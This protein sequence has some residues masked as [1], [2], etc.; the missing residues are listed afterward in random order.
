[1][2]SPH[3]SGPDGKRLL[4]AL[5]IATTI[6][7]GWQYFYE[8]PQ[9]E[10]RREQAL[11]AAESKAKPDVS[12]AHAEPKAVAL[13]PITAVADAPRVKINSA[14]LHGSISLQGLRFDDLAL[15]NYRENIN[16]ESPEVRLLNHAGSADAYFAEVGMLAGDASVAV[17]D[18]TTRWETN[19][20]EMSETKPVTMRWNNGAGLVFEKKISIDKDFMFTITTTVKN[21]GSAPVTLFPY[22]LIS[23]NYADT[24]KHY[25][26][27]HEGPLGVMHNVLE[28]L[29]YKALREDGPKE[30]TGTQGWIGMT[31]KYWLTA[32]IPEAGQT[33]DANYKHFKRGGGIDAAAEGRDAYQTDLRGTA[34]HVPVGETASFTVRL[35]AGAKLV[36]LLDRYSAQ[37][38]IPLFDRAVDF[39]SLY[40]LTKP[41]FS[42]LNYFHGLVGNFGIAILLL[43]VVIKILLFPLASK[44]MT[45]MA[46]MK[47]LMPKMEE[48]KARYSNDKMKMNQ[49]MMAL[50]KREKVNP[51]AGCL[52]ILLQIPVFLALYRVLFVT[53]EMRHAPFFGWVSDLSVPDP[54]N[55]FTLFGMVPW[56]APSFL[57]LGIWPMIMCATMVIQQRISPKPADE[58]QA[59]VMTYMPF[60]FL[61]L[62]A[63]FPAGLVIYW[64]WNN[65]LT[66]LQ[67]LYI[68]YR[69]EKKGLK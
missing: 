40:F 8:R 19:S 69:L 44:S 66:I 51:V 14:S 52:P 6:M 5:A 3:T 28:D 34:M 29:T 61:F 58:I 32:L 50:Y 47:Q 36:H 9:L 37:Y 59:A 17:P 7:M 68:N 57:H 30:F 1:M 67:Q 25:I 54:T 35:F 62:F 53:I 20:R 27:M 60:I 26:I 56:D 18:A 2:T 33:F 45:A 55:L 64:A 4:I 63:S 22:G 12:T 31:D 42:L 46:R 21:S 41:I 38:T 13:A 16:P 65:T 23:R 24:S 49:E 10:A 39:G 11:V 43:T 48:I 15:V